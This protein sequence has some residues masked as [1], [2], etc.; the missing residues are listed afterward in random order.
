MREVL[1]AADE[2]GW[3]VVRVDVREGIVLEEPIAGGLTIR[4]SGRTIDPQFVR[5]LPEAREPKPDVP[6][7][8]TSAAER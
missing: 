5:D 3:V 1:E 2:L 7:E 6:R 8:A 4:I